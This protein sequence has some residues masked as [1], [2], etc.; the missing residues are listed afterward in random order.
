MNPTIIQPEQAWRMTVEQLRMGMPQANFDSWVRDAQFMSWDGSMMTIG[1]ANPYARD[2]L[3][4][5]LTSTVNNLLSGTLV[6]PVS[7]QFI[8][9]DIPY[10]TELQ[11]DEDCSDKEKISKQES[12]PKLITLQAEYQSLY[13]EIVQP[14]QVIV[15]PGYFLRFIPMLGVE[16]AWLYIGFRQ[17][18]YEAGASKRPDK[19]VGASA[20]K[21]AWY[22]GMSTRTFWRWAAKPSTWKRLRWLV[23]PVEEK[24]KWNRGSDGR[25]HQATR[26]YKVAMTM[27]MTPYD[28]HYLC[29]WFYH[30]LADGKTPITVLQTALNTPVDEL[31]PWP[32]MMPDLEEINSEPHSVRDVV[33]GVFGSLISENEKAHFNE[34][35]EKLAQH[36]MPSKDLVFLTH[37]FVHHWL[38]RLG[39]G[40]G[41]FVTFMRDRCYINQRTGE[42]RDEVWLNQGYA[43]AARWLGLKR[44]KTIWEWLRIPEVAIFLKEIRRE[45]GCWEEAPRRIKVLLG[46]PM[47]D[48]HQEY[49]NA[50]LMESKLGASDI[51]SDSCQ[52][53]AIGA[54][55]IHSVG[56][57]ASAIG[58]SVTHSKEN[59]AADIGASVT[60][61]AEQGTSA[62]G[63]PVI[64]SNG[65]ARHEIG[66][67][68]THNGAIDIHKIGA[69][70]T[71]VGADDTHSIGASGTL[72]WRNC[73]GFNSL[74]PRFKHLENTQTTT[75][76]DEDREVVG[77][78]QMADLLSTNR[79]S[80]KNQQWLLEKRAK[81]QL[82]ISW[83]LYATSN[84]GAGIREPVGHA[85]SRLSQD[86]IHGAGGAFDRLAALPASE[87]TALI[88]QELN[89]QCP[90]KSDWKTA[91]ASAP[92]ARIRAL[93]DQLGIS[94]PKEN[95]W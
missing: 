2:W 56:V 79:V 8:V 24:A 91:M 38:P 28:E 86:P 60:H 47:I 3:T 46:E 22:S 55:A 5:R 25:P 39:S 90:W 12:L 89:G 19:K 42:L 32:E 67:S 61:S 4:N 71:P 85:V 37:Y 84:S 88:R 36:L 80:P 35:T 34:L 64:L 59:G 92:R 69:S 9:Q 53:P 65:T 17:A 70:V 21:V 72:D 93:A 48:Q 15:F 29:A 27:P 16:L 7:V 94:I 49:A 66:A 33:V 18:A 31:L 44:V 30:Q 81:P 73:H 78:W 6:Q 57:D 23:T 11:Q 51:H 20:K 43:E 95:D 14:D 75:V 77:E 74:T 40:P 62:I 26:S 82:F 54:T 58:G 13:D 83:L 68:D 10:A 76:P 1:V 50:A 45:N 41:W 52:V 63:A 87:L